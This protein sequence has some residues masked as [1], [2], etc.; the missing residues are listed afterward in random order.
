M[1]GRSLLPIL[2]IST[3]LAVNSQ[4][5]QNSVPKSELDIMVPDTKIVMTM[6]P[7]EINEMNIVLN[8]ADCS[9]ALFSDVVAHLKEDGIDV[10]TTKSCNGVN[11][12]NATII[13]LDEQ[14]SSGGETVI[15]APYD[16]SRVGHSDSLALAM[17]TAFKQDGFQVADVQCGKSGYQ[18]D[19]NGEI[20]YT[21]P[22]GT[23]I[24]MDDDCDSSFVTISLGTHYRDAAQVAKTIENG[25]ARQ[26]LYLKSD[27][28]QTDL[29]YHADSEDKIEDVA[30]YFGTDAARLKNY[31]GI[32]ANQ[33][34]NSQAVVNPYVDEMS[35]FDFGRF[36]QVEEQNQ[37]TY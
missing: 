32:E 20:V 23:E 10:T 28:N 13:T 22:T 5:V 11:V 7:E 17:Q 6:E 26:K 21:V 12:D 16:N 27:D 9:D 18:E 24:A 35:A 8:D 14:Y 29:I 30:N 34:H 3:F 25:L 31:N 36:F 37:K 2:L 1:F 4:R 15:F 33:F 19:E